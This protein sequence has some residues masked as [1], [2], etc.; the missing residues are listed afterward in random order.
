MSLNQKEGRKNNNWRN[1]VS[2]KEPDNQGKM[3][4]LS[5]GMEMDVGG[6]TL[7]TVIGTEAA[8][9]D[10]PLPVGEVSGTLVT[11]EMLSSFMKDAEDV[12]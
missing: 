1:R 9:A 3:F 12:R 5:A 7:V 6:T 10:H 8:A 2:S 4:V 11:Q